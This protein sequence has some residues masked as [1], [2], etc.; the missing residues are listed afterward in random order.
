MKEADNQSIVKSFTPS[1]TPDSEMG[2][3]GVYN[4]VLYFD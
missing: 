2:Y 4:G 1:Q 3:C